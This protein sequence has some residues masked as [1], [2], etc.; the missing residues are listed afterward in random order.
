MRYAA[1]SQVVARRLREA[2]VL[3]SRIV[4]IYDGVPLLRRAAED[5]SNVLVPA[6]KIEPALDRLPLVVSAN[7]ERDLEQA[8][9]LVYLS[10]AEGLGSAVL[11]AMSAS[12]P[13]IASDLPALREII[14]PE[15]N[16]LF[17]PVDPQALE[18]LVKDLLANPARRKRLGTAGRATVE[19]RF[20]E[21][22]MVEATMALYREVLAGA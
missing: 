4:V 12:V 2:G 14:E 3:A 20:T 16:G 21:S 13:V 6:G 11:L 22:H 17:A 9:V 15:Q 19:A 18:S 10:R 7:L 5:A 1:V 8:A